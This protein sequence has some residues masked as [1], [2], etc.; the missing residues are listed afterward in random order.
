MA[1]PWSKKDFNLF[2]ERFICQEALQAGGVAYHIRYR[3]RYKACIK[4]LSKIAPP[5]SIDVLDVGGGQIALMC[6]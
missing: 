1:R 5:H 2:Y 3:S 6:S 4:R